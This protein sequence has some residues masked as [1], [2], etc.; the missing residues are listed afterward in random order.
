VLEHGIGLE[1]GAKIYEDILI[2][3]YEGAPSSSEDE[4]FPVW[5]NGPVRR[6]KSVFRDSVV[7]Q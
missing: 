7:T 6:T 3:M 2:Q 4:R 5:S 1:E